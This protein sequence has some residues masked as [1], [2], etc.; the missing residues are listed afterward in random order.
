[1]SL[2]ERMEA[3]ASALSSDGEGSREQAGPCAGVARRQGT[4][5]RPERVRVM[6]MMMDRVGFGEVARIVKAG[7]MAQAS[8]ELRP[9]L[10]AVINA[11]ESLEVNAEERERLIEEVLNDV[12]GMG[13]LQPLIEDDSITEIMV[14]GRDR[15]FIEREG[16]LVP[17]GRLFESEEQIRTLID[18]IISPLGRRV[19]ER[20]PM[21]NARLPSG[22]RVNAV[23]PPIAIDGPILT[24]RKFSDR[25]SALDHLVRLGSLPRWYA[26]L[27]SFAVRLRQDLAVA[28]GTGSGKTTLLNALSCEIPDQERIVTIEDSAELKFT[29]H[30]HVVR[31][32]AREASIE[33]AGEVS[34]HDLLVNALRMRP[35]RIVVG[36]VRNREAID[37]LEAMSTGHD[38]SLTTLHAGSAEEAVVRLTL[39]ARYGIDLSTDLIE[40]QIAMALDGI[41][42]SVRMPSGR[43]FVSSYSGVSRNNDGGVKLTRYVSFD[44]ARAEWELVEEPGFIEEALRSGALSKEEVEE[45]R[46]QCL[47]SSARSRLSA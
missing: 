5:L 14:N 18:R 21:V 31:L 6:R 41:V 24:I 3:S 10:E 33:G 2:L 46:S 8:L 20:S 39:L 22:F 19:D 27:L 11:D 9:A 43:R 16:T 32:E 40:E 35:D 26:R 44:A 12:A 36:E 30:P 29:H 47:A 23:I 15:A 28:G 17:M 7:D 34:I 25:I 37:M 38:G 45:W 1:M 13:P 4:L 42:M